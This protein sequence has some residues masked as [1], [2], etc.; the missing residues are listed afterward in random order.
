[1]A[2]GDVI[3][4]TEGQM[5]RD[6]IDWQWETDGLQIDLVIVRAEEEFPV[7]L[8]REPAESWGIVF[9]DVLFDGVRTCENR[10]AFCF[11]AQL[12]RG[13]RRSLYVRDDDYRLSFLQGN[14]VTLTNVTD[15]DID[16]IIEQHLSPL[17]V[18][19]HAVSPAVRS[20]L[21]C[22]R[23]DRAL[24]VFDQLVTAGIEV[25]TQVVL[26]PG[27]N[28][29]DEL[30]HT[31]EWLA[32]REG[33]LS[34]GVVPLGFT[35][36]QSRYSASY[37]ASASA[38]EVLDQIEPWRQAFKA[39]H[40]TFWVYAADE[41]YLAAGRETPIAEEYDGYPQYENGIGLVRDF[42]DQFLEITSGHSTVSQTES[43]ARPAII[44][45]TLFAPVLQAL[46][47]RARM[48][49]RAR[50]LAVENQYFGGNVSVSGLLTGADIIRELKG[51]G[52]PAVCVLPDV[53]LNAD[54]VTLD[55]MSVDMMSHGAG[56]EIQVV[57]ADAEGLV[58]AFL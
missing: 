13:L 54:G 4:S 52:P 3:V 38:A 21:V 45:G 29:G 33:V 10:C 58:S 53:A 56:C 18:S 25:H 2:S 42:S 41:L 7:R 44:T 16:R 23:D 43:P 40:G 32:E 50:V 11:M 31:L 57:K 37:G 28:D 14:F 49:D 19:V 5:L 26:V 20:E 6:V 30:S 36:H 27:V 8:N 46:L 47:A 22:A 17:Y 55:D 34:V 48:L 35:R 15:S 1:L 51:I 24:G 12:P 9:S 39:Q